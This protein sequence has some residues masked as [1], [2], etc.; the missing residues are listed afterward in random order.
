MIATV[1]GRGGLES[2]L[3]IKE[4]SGDVKPRE[5]HLVQER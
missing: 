5:E 2:L 4:K 1:P 3:S